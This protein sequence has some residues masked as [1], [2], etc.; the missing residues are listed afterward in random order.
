M[1]CLLEVA[2]LNFAAP[3]RGTPWLTTL[4]DQHIPCRQSVLVTSPRV[5]VHLSKVCQIELEPAH[6]RVAEVRT[7]VQTRLLF[8]VQHL[9]EMTR[10]ELLE[11]PLCPAAIIPQRIAKHV[12][13]GGLDKRVELGKCLAA[14]G[15]KR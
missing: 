1:E 13:E 12:D 14:L 8:L 9:A 2:L 5:D 15:A 3:N 10:T 7:R 6:V 11:G 4:A